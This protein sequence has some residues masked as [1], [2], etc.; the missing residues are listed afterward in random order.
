MVKV[1]PADGV[2]INAPEPAKGKPEPNVLTS[3]ASHG[4]TYTRRIR[5]ATVRDGRLE[6][7]KPTDRQSTP[8]GGL[9]LLVAVL[10][11]ALLALV[12]SNLVAFSFFTAG[13]MLVG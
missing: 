4:K 5:E 9:F 3:L 12:G 1:A 11:Q 6:V 8:R 2:G 10:A 13:H 7:L